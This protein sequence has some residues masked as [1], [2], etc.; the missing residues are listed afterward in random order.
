MKK[1]KHSAFKKDKSSFGNPRKGQRF[2][3][4]Q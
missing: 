1:C 3:L 4:I 2:I